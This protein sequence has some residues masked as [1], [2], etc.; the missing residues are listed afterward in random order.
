MEPKEASTTETG[1]LPSYPT[2]RT[3][4]FALPAELET[5]RIHQPTTRV[6]LW[7][8]SMPWLVTR[9]AD[10]RMVLGDKRFSADSARP[11]YPAAKVV[12]SHLGGR[13]AAR[14][15]ITMD[16]PEHG[17]YRKA[18]MGEFTV[19]RIEALRPFTE[20]KINALLDA[21]SSGPRPADIM[22][23]FAMPLPSVV[24]CHLLG[25]P[26]QD[27]PFFQEQS[28]IM[29]DSAAGP[30]APGRALG[31]LAAYMGKLVVAKRAQPDDGLLSRLVERQHSDCMSDADVVSMAMVLLVAGHETTANMIGLGVLYLMQHPDLA[32]RVRR[33]EPETVQAVVEELLRLATVVHTGKR[34]VATQDVVVGET[35]IRAG[36]GVIAAVDAANRDEDEFS[37]SDEFDLNR[38]S[39]R[40]LAFGFGIH[41]C[42]GQ[43]MARIELR[44]AYTALLRRFPSLRLAVDEAE[45]RFRDDMLIYGVH[46]LPVTW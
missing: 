32:D 41:Q 27:H 20:S 16:D 1:Y 11:G 30:A 4:P 36:E 3:C 46:S 9:Y 44:M 23:S 19:R 39:N 37:E 21:M 40:H 17:R 12:S 18:L 26:Y 35:L 28:R 7:D 43:Q 24:I 29:L 45:L 14:T 38:P 31:A 10:V 13:P 6:R 15:F 5:I 34:R 42:M 25:V 22:T 2:H 33:G 8:G